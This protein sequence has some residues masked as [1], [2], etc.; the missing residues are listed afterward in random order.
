MHAADTQAGREVRCQAC[1]AVQRVPAGEG[2]SITLDAPAAGNADGEAPGQIP[3]ATGRARSAGVIDCGGCGRPFPATEPLCPQCGWVNAQL[4]RRK[5]TPEADGSGPAPA[6]LAA[7]YLRS[8][9]FGLTNFRSL[10]ALVL[11]SLVEFVLLGLLWALGHG[12]HT[13]LGGIVVLL[14]MLGVPVQL[15][16]VGYILRCYLEVIVAVLVAT[17]RAPNAPGFELR[18]LYATGVR[19][20]LLVFVYVLPVITLPLLPVALLAMAHADDERAFDLRWAWRAAAKHR[21]ALAQL[22]AVL[23]LWLVVL[24]ALAGWLWPV[25]LLARHGI[26][27]G[28]V[29]TMVLPAI[30]YLLACAGFRCVGLLGRHNPDILDTLPEQASPKAIV[31]SIVGGLIVTYLLWGLIV[32]AVL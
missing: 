28:W 10:A 13:R 23:G 18:K 16:L 6:P 26:L 2:L 1:G 30:I 12:I 29:T 24:L 31:A 7:E 11:V 32:P 8:I 19:G 27:V 20:L 9:T 22:W 21:R 25:A 15:V 17:G 4:L 3:I 5:P 14:L